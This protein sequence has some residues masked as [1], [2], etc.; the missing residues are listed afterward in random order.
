MV[1]E[2]APSV[3]VAS[4]TCR[5]LVALIP[6]AALAVT[7]LIVND[8][9]D[10][11]QHQTALPHNFWYLV[12]LEFALAGLLAGVLIRLVA[13][14]E[15]VLADR[16][17]KHISTKIMEHASKLDLTTFED[18]LFYDKME[19]A[20]VQGTD[21]LVMIQSTGMLIQQLVTTISM[22]GGIIFLSPWI[23]LV[24]IACVIPAFMGETHFAFMGYALNFKQTPAK[25]EMDYLRIVGGSKESAKELKLFGLANYLVGRYSKLSNELHAQNVDLAKRRLLVGTAFTTLSA[26]GYYGSYAFVIYKTVM[27]SL[28]IGTFYFMVGAIALASS[29]IQSVFTT[30]STI[31]DQAMFITDLLDFFN[32][33]PRVFSKPNALRTPRPI[34]LG[35]EFQNVSFSYPGQTRQVLSNVS[36]S[37]RPTERIA[38]VGEN[39]QGKT[40]IVKLLTRLYDPTGGRIL[41]D[42][43]D[44]R[45]Y[46]LEDLWKEIGV[47]FQDFVRYDMTASENIAIGRIEE[48]DNTFRV[49]SAA[50]KSLAEGV[51]RKLPHGYNQLLGRRFEGGTDL[52]GG[53]WQ[54]IALARAYLRDAQVLVLDEPT[55]ALDARSEHEVFERFAELT[56]GK[57]AL[58]ISHRFST[59]KMADR[60]LVL[61]GGRIAEQGPHD[62]LLQN[63]GRY[64]E[65][66]ELQ[67]AS[68]R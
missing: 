2:A 45:D 48:Q 24:L 39:G 58:L 56:K 41:L 46:E 26:L 63:K 59:V 61:E 62:E 25:R 8:I 17:S 57:M 20:R 19:R 28:D 10:Y 53:E 33:K 16:Y 18:P 12:G 67:A 5:V 27:G 35:F 52:S 55:A 60:I 9:V 22:A 7:R 44:L 38:L 4:L 64:A 1:W 21:R 13:Y 37:L 43:V 40:T 51:I 34:R 31:A 29:N 6:L 50:Q 36:F 14:F 47:I 23:L 66:F 65:M 15:I 54:K 42:G 32:L 30:F 68:Y 3:I 11:R 49:R